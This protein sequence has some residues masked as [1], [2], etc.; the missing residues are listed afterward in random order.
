MEESEF[1]RLLYY[2]QTNAGVS[3]IS[4]QMQE[5]GTA[6]AFQSSALNIVAFW[7][8]VLGLNYSTHL[9][10]YLLLMD[11]FH[12]HFSHIDYLLLIFQGFFILSPTDG[13]M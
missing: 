2:F 12:S 8:A 13:S 6:A 3:V 10:L 4:R 11:Y 5:W 9:S 1:W 7:E